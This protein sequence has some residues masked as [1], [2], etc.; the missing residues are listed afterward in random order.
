MHFLG[1]LFS[2]SCIMCMYSSEYLEIS[3]PLGMYLLM[4]LLVFSTP[5]FSQDMVGVTEVDRHAKNP[6]QLFVSFK[7]NIIVERQRINHNA[8]SHFKYIVV[9]GF[10]VQPYYFPD[11]CVPAFA[12]VQHQQDSMTRLAGNNE[13]AF[14]VSKSPFMFNDFGPLVYKYPSFEFGCF[15]SRPALFL[16]LV[17]DVFF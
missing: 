9:G 12:F 4:S 14:P 17:V 5:P 6:R 1:R 13:V 16:A 3:L 10:H 8:T 2:L 11:E 7:D 15:N